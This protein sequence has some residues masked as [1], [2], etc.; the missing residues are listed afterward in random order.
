MNE[1]LVD[2]VCNQD[3]NDSSLWMILKESSCLTVNGFLRSCNLVEK[4]C[5]K[6]ENLF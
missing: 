1:F 4:I 6:L 3:D 5:K 2:S